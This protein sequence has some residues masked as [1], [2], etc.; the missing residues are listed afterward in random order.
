M[1]ALFVAPTW[2]VSKRGIFV[3]F[4]EPGL[5]KTFHRQRAIACQAGIKNEM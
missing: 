4:V 2:Q 3:V 1:L 5:N